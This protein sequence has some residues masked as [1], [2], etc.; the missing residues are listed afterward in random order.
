MVTIRE[1]CK[2]VGITL[3]EFSIIAE[4]FP[5]NIYRVADRNDVNFPINRVN[6][7]Y[8]NTKDRFGEGLHPRDYINGILF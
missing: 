1:Y 3:H 2:K 6:I 8:K 7:I 5:A 4:V